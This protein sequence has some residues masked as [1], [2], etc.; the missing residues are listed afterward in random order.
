MKKTIIANWKS[1]KNE[2]EALEWLKIVGP[3][4]IK[5]KNLEISVAPQLH[6]LSLLNREIRSQRY[7]LSL[8]AQD[9][10]PFEEGPYTGEVSAKS[11]QG[12]VKYVLV[13]HSERRKNFKETNF[14]VNLKVKQCLDYQLKPIV[15]LSDL[16][17]LKGI[18]V[19]HLRFD[20]QNFL[21]E[22]ISAVKGVKQDDFKKVIFMYEPPSAISKPL[23]PIGT[24]QAADIDD[25]LKMVAQI[26]KISPQSK[27][28]YGGSVKSENVNDFLKEP[29]IDGIVSGTAS[30]NAS[31][32]IK[33]IQ[34]ASQI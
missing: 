1:N 19:D 28:F 17:T 3:K 22:I 10:S 13:G 24:G 18:I 29:L 32:F 23:G 4:L 14:L 30:L 26:K 27:I 12:L 7:S 2:K 6:L 8:S 11:L 34:N 20:K 33:L 25:V 16:V 21:N 9:V 31:E 15:C 5:R